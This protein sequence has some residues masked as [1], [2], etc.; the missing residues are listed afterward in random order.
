METEL[1]DAAE[2]EGEDEGE[3]AVSDVPVRARIFH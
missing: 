1:D 2:E 3:E